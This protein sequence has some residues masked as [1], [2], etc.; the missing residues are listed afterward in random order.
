VRTM[1][2]QSN[3]VFSGHCR[4]GACCVRRGG[5]RP[6]VGRRSHVD[7]KF[8]RLAV[9]V[10]T[11]FFLSFIVAAVDLRCDDCDERTRPVRVRSSQ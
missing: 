4:W 5:C 10:R 7:T 8:D 9:D 3:S 2:A 1:M 6:H 11:Y